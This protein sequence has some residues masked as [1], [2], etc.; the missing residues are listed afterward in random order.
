MSRKNTRVVPVREHHVH[1]NTLIP[2]AIPVDIDLNLASIAI[3]RRC[4]KSFYRSVEATPTCDAYFRCPHCRGLRA[5][6]F[7]LIS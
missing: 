4:G 7:C 5:S 2:T 3:C 1:Q 6:N